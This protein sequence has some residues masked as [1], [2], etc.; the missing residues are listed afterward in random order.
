MLLLGATCLAAGTLSSPEEVWTLSAL[1]LAL[2]LFSAAQVGRESGLH[3]LRQKKDQH[4]FSQD[5]AT[6]SLAVKMLGPHELGVGNTIQV[7]GHQ[8]LI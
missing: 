3:R 1:M 6:D 5:V 7:R 2:N 4:F 8:I